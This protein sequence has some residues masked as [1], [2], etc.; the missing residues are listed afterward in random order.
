VRA[1]P[2]TRIF[3][4]NTLNF[5]ASILASSGSAIQPIFLGLAMSTNTTL[6]ARFDGTVVAP[7]GTVIFGAGT[8]TTFSGS[9]F[10]RTIEVSPGNILACH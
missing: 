10:A 6:A 9:F 8:P 5:N 2:T 7:N 4:Q 1:T 3:V